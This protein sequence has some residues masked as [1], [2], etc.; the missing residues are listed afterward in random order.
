MKIFKKPRSTAQPTQSPAG[1]VTAI[2]AYR[3]PLQRLRPRLALLMGLMVFSATAGCAALVTGGG[4]ADMTGLVTASDIHVEAYAEADLVV[5]AILA[6]EQPAVRTARNIAFEVPAGV[7]ADA[8]REGVSN[9][10]DG[11]VE[12][13]T[14]RAILH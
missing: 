12:A 3:T 11:T 8:A 14:Y 10:L 9:H 1:V 5:A 4:D 13:H 2:P 7:I 6:G